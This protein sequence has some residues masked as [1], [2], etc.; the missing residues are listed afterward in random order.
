MSDK[1]SALAGL[2]VHSREIK[3]QLKHG[4]GARHQLVRVPLPADVNLQQGFDGMSPF[5]VALC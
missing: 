3:D 4:Q 2:A 5:V 1:S